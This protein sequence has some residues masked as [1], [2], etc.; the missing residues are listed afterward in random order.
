[1]LLW[2]S[3]GTGHLCPAVSTLSQWWEWFLR[4]SCHP[5]KYQQGG[6]A[7]CHMISVI[8]SLTWVQKYFA[9]SQTQ[10]SAAME[11]CHKYLPVLESPGTF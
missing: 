2:M 5:T 9:V 10:E 8:W 4:H 6:T 3:R 7:G 1:M 11:R